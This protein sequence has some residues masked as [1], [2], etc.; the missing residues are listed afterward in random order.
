MKKIRYCHNCRG[1]VSTR[2]IL[3]AAGINY[4]EIFCAKCGNSLAHQR[5]VRKDLS[6][7][8]S[9]HTPDSLGIHYCELCH[10]PEPHFRMNNYSNVLE[11]RIRL[12]VLRLLETPHG[13]KDEPGN[14]IVVCEKCRDFIKHARSFIDVNLQNEYSVEDFKDEL[15]WHHIRGEERITL[16][17]K[18]K[19]L[20]GLS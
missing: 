8:E 11:L 13:G 19:K 14:I 7:S 5:I 20:T 18:F 15:S 16:V 12:S 9:Q 4:A 2:Q 6:W 10:K 3:P 17:E 1:I